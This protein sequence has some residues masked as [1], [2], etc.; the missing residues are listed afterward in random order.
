MCAYLVAYVS[1]DSRCATS[2][3][4]VRFEERGFLDGSHLTEVPVGDPSSA[5]CLSDACSSF[6]GFWFLAPV[7]TQTCH[8]TEAVTLGFVSP[9]PGS[10]LC[11]PS[12][13]GLALLRASVAAGLPQVRSTT[14]YHKL[15][16]H[17]T[18]FSLLQEQFTSFTNGPKAWAW[19]WSILLAAPGFQAPAA[20]WEVYIF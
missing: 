11:W 14:S 10:C 12:R 15:K 8:L 18:T 6:R 13:F 16:T 19:R 20:R 9:T 2:A 5:T 17:A 7:L 4:R 3:S 1:R